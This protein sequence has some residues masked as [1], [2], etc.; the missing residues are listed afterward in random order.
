VKDIVHVR[1]QKEVCAFLL[2][3]VKKEERGF[4]LFSGFLPDFIDEDWHR[5]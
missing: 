4:L 5:F 3:K 2:Q 1:G